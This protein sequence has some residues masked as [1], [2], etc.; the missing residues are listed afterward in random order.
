MIFDILFVLIFI[1]A[2]F[3]GFTRGLIMQLSTLTALI[4]GI[5]CSM[6]FSG[7]IS[8]AI[9]SKNEVGKEFIHILVFTILFLI[10]LV[11]VFLIGKIIERLIEAM[12]LGII[13]RILGSIFALIK[14]VLLVSTLL[15]ILNFIDSHVRFLPEKKIRESHIYSPLSALVPALFPGGFSKMVSGKPVE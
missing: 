8:A 6:R 9:I 14:Y 13:N 11:I 7:Y 3:R 12:F 1:W 10:I 15:M 4:L 2:V 5:Y